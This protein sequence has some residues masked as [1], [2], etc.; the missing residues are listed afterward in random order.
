MHIRMFH[1]AC[2]LENGGQYRFRSRNSS[3]S[4]SAKM[5]EKVKFRHFP[6]FFFFFFTL[7]T[8]SYLID[9][10]YS[11][12]P[13]AKNIQLRLLR[14]FTLYP[15]RNMEIERNHGK[16]EEK[17][18]RNSTALHI[19]SN[20]GESINTVEK[21]IRNMYFFC[22]GTLRKIYIPYFFYT[23]SKEILAKLSPTYLYN[24]TRNSSNLLVSNVKSIRKDKIRRI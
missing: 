24:I 15:S 9:R 12:L 13:S 8:T 2:H 18:W 6:S 10:I 11:Q 17:N 4:V 20:I 22:Y 16:I 5:G 1:F 3:A 21:S 23:P 7:S 14:I 19:F